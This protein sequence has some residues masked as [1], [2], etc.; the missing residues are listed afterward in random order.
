MLALLLFLVLI[1]AALAL[2]LW[3]AVLGCGHA[4]TARTARRRFARSRYARL[5]W[6]R[7]RTA[8]LRELT[9]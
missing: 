6:G 9:R 7:S 2:G 1:P 8:R 4:L 5:G 3:A